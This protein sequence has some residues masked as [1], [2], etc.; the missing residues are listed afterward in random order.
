MREIKLIVE[1]SIGLLKK[2]E[3]EASFLIYLRGEGHQCRQEHHQNRS[4]T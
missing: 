1:K 2:K 3:G 4:R